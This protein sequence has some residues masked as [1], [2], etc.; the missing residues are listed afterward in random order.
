MISYKK[1]KSKHSLCSLLIGAL[2]PL[3]LW[4]DDKESDKKEKLSV[5]SMLVRTKTHQTQFSSSG[6]NMVQIT[7]WH[8]LLSS[9]SWEAVNLFEWICIHCGKKW[10]RR[11]FCRVSG[12]ENKILPLYEEDG[13]MDVIMEDCHE[14]WIGCKYRRIIKYWCSQF[15]YISRVIRGHSH[16]LHFQS[17]L[18]LCSLHWSS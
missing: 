4:L 16:W 10:I 8:M 1:N 13:F 11:P 15:T 6:G 2:S 5:F 7:H 17:R 9:E 18:W 12:L 3:L 14:A